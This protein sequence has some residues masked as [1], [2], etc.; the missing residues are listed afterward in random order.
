MFLDKI[1]QQ[2]EPFIECAFTGSTHSPYDF[3]NH[4]KPEWE[5]AEK[6][7]MNSVIYADQCLSDFIEAT[8]K[9]DWHK[10]TLFVIVADHGHA[11]P[12][13]SNPSDSEFY[14]IP[15][16]LYG[17]AL[18]ESAR[19]MVIDKVGS[20][21]DIAQT[22]L[23]QMK[24]DT[25]NDYPWSKDLLNPNVPEFALH[26]TTRGFGWVTPQGQFTFHLDY[27]KYIVN[28]FDADVLSKERKR[29]NA[30]MQLLYEQ[31]EEL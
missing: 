17:P 14:R 29:C 8:K 19:G 22:L 26:T 28:T 12:Y 13:V 23:Y 4:N 5:G 31:Y 11:S 15:L 27:Q 3:P 9:Q 1:N 18:K 24:V 6:K 7:F 16:L 30:F 21:A 20:Q 2:E 10:N 25:G